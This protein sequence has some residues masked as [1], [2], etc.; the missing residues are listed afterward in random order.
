ME[1]SG[2]SDTFR[3]I[4]FRDPETNLPRNGGEIHLNDWVAQQMGLPLSVGFG[5]QNDFVIG[6]LLCNWMSDEGFLTKFDLQNRVIDPTGDTMFGKGRVINKYVE[7][8]QHLVDIAVW[9]D[10]IRGYIASLGTATVALPA[11]KAYQ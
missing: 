5:V 2:A 1:A 6:R 8:G 7:N 11:R 9:C 3:K 10:S 4:Q